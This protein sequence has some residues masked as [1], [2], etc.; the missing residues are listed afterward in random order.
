MCFLYTL[1]RA[2]AAH[3]EPGDLF[4]DIPH[5]APDVIRLTPIAGEVRLSGDEHFLIE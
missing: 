5:S 2:D 4:F 1:D 3:T